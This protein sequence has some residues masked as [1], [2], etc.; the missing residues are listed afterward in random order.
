MDNQ[1]WTIQSDRQHR[2]LDT[3]G[4]I[5]NGQSRDTGNIGYLTERGQSRIDNQEWTIQ[6]DRQHRALDTEGTIKNRQ[7]RDT[8]NIGH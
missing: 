5:K 8:G 1:E 2:A 7:S 4:T 6:S 3:E